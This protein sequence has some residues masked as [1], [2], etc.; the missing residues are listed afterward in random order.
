[1][2]LPLGPSNN[3]GKY[4][5]IRPL[6]NAR[7]VCTINVTEF[8]HQWLYS[9]L[10]GPG[11]FFSFVIRY[12]VDMFPWTGDQSVIRLLPTHRSAQTQNKLIQISMPRVGFEPTNP[13]FERAKTVH[14]LEHGAI[15]ICNANLWNII[16]DK[17]I[18]NPDRIF[19]YQTEFALPV[20]S[21]Q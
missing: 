18:Y 15:V 17:L 14:A 4:A 7:F 16:I 9:P 13:T 5:V 21:S 1:M 8:I 11:R 3:Y 6:I 2:Y 12:R 10:L 19:L 20:T